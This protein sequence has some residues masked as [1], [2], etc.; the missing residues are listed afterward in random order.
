MVSVEN[1]VSFCGKQDVRFVLDVNHYDDI[2]NMSCLA[3]YYKDSGKRCPM[4]GS[5]L[6]CSLFDNKFGYW[7]VGHFEKL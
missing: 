1:L 3:C 7:G 5:D 2:H 4:I 6:L